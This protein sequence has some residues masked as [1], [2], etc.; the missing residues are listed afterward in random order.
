MYYQF[1]IWWNGTKY[2]DNITPEML[3]VR[4]RECIENGVNDFAWRKMK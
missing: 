1:T 2:T 3:D 4:I